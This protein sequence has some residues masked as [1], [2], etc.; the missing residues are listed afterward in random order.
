VEFVPAHHLS[1]LDVRPLHP[2][3]FLWCASLWLVWGEVL[4]SARDIPACAHGATLYVC[5]DALQRRSHLLLLQCSQPRLQVPLVD[6]DWKHRLDHV[7]RKCGFL[8]AVKAAN[9]LVFAA[10]AEFLPAQRH[11]QEVKGHTCTQLL[12][13]VVNAVFSHSAIHI[14]LRYVYQRR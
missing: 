4:R 9:Q 11:Q 12:W 10:T 3:L 7:N 8:A 13:R 6:R 1:L 2:R 5:G 14:T